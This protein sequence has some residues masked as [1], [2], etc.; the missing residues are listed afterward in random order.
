MSID[1][2]VQEVDAT[3]SK[4]GNYCPSPKG[5]LNK[6][7]I[8]NRV[9][10]ITMAMRKIIMDMRFMPC[11]YFIHGVYGSFGSLFLMYKY[12]A[13]CLKIPIKSSLEE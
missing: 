3:A 11:I 10:I 2:A 5:Y 9:T 4:P 7:I 13:T 6:G 8:T 12:S 1:F